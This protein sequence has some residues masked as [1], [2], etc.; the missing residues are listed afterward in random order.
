MRLDYADLE[1]FGCSTKCFFLDQA[2]C[3][4]VCSWPYCTNQPFIV[5]NVI[6][7]AVPA[8][9]ATQSALQQKH[10][11]Q[12]VITSWRNM[13]HRTSCPWQTMDLKPGTENQ[14]ET[15]LKWCS[16]TEMWGNMATKVSSLY[17]ESHTKVKKDIWPS[18]NNIYWTTCNMFN[19]FGP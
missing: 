15:Y 16:I 11:K 14:S 10:D 17:L 7:V 2:C 5:I 9:N 1:G 3:I 13:I 6:F 4:S 12:Q 18:F 19:S 8:R